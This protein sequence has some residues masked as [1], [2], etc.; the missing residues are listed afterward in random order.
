[1]LLE[2]L[3]LQETEVLTEHHVERNHSCLQ[4]LLSR[5]KGVN[6]VTVR[7]LHPRAKKIPTNH[8]SREDLSN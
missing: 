4:T 3:V 2:P 6:T 5:P 1:M 8:V 7:L